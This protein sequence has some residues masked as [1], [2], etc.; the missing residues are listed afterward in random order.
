VLICDVW[1][2]RLSSEER[3]LIT[4]VMKTLDHFNGGAAGQGL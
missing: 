4:R 1:N 2:P 3:D